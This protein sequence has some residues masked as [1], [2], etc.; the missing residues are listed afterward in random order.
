MIRASISTT[1]TLV[2]VG[3][4]ILMALMV[5]AVHARTVPAFP[6]AE[7]F[8]SVTKGGRG[9][10]VIAVTNLNDS[11]PGSLRAAVES[12][13]PRT[14]V[15]RVSGTIELKSRL[16][17]LHPHITIAGQ[18]APGDGITLRGQQV[19]ISADEVIIRYIR[20]RMGDETGTNGDAITG[21]YNKNIILDHISSSWGTDEV[22]SLYHNSYVTIQYSI[23]SEAIGNGVRHKFGG[24]WGS[25]YSS[26]HHNLLAHNDSR[27][28]RF[29]SGAGHVDFR[30][31][32]IYNWGYNSTYGG[33]KQEQGNPKFNFSI[34]NIVAN[35]YKPGPATRPNVRSRIVGPST[36]DGAADHGHWYVSN[37][38]VEGSPQVTADNWLGVES[39]RPDIIENLRL[40]S[41]FW[42]A[43]P[44]PAMPIAQES[45][46]EACKSVLARA[47]ASLK[48]DAVDARIVDEVRSGTATYGNGIINSQRDVGGW[49]ELR[50]LPAPADTDGDG[51]PDWWEIKYG[52]N[53]NDPADAKGDRNGSG[54]TNIE[55]Y[56][57]GTDP[58]VFVD[59]T[60]RQNNVNTLTVGSFKP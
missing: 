9:G 7:G 22:L 1:A 31:N 47:G 59:Y 8:G 12:Q 57:N 24:I 3:A 43:E 54:Y 15:F 18:T 35:Y 52:L 49:P 37:N 44:W 45:A 36:R 58:T 51:M 14:V 11:G 30:N 20:F 34:I 42:L 56:L 25:N 41:G 13:G 26:Y 29:A 10:A 21:R 33:E 55:E 39:S 16:S 60:R 4:I 23:I 38:F 6:G 32:V 2:R 5:S 50:N 19:Q 40:G 53:P 27:N 28:P 17:I 46:E 48:R